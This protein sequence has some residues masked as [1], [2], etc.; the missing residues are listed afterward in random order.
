MLTNAIV[1]YPDNTRPLDQ[2]FQDTVLCEVGKILQ[3]AVINKRFNEELLIDPKRSIENGYF[4][5]KFHLPDEVLQKI[6]MIRCNTLDQFT[7]EIINLFNAN[8]IPELVE[9]M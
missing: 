3:A 7:S 1:A 4:G 8:K 2:E 9:T 6:S 5:E